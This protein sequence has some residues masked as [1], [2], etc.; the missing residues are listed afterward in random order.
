MKKKI[1]KKQTTS[2]NHIM[3][4][5][6]KMSFKRIFLRGLLFF[7]IFMAILFVLN[8]YVTKDN[9]RY[10]V[11]NTSAQPDAFYK[12][13]IYLYPQETT[14]VSVKAKYPEKFTHTY[15]KY[16][17]SWRVLAEP[18]GDLTDLDT[19]RYLYALYWEGIDTAQ[20]PAKD[21]FIVKGSDTISFLEE[22]LA[23]L[24][25]TEREAD[26]FIIYWLP[27]LENNSY[28][29]IRFQSLEQQNKNM[30]LDI[31]PAPETLIRVMME[32]QPLDERVDLP[33]QILPPSPTR[34]GFTVV[35]WGG[36]E[37]KKD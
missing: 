6:K 35:E 22:K 4:S 8:W 11:V 20:K 13:I 2:K 18:N 10:D 31:T 19:G 1:H 32:Y 7:F 23:T 36:T 12:P 28:N 21:G 24:G 26:E 29:L 25:L 16:V 14:E 37:L 3:K 9:C 27:K 30:P 15:P 33:E 34:T 5:K 17:D